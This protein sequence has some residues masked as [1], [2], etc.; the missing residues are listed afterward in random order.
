MPQGIYGPY[1][2]VAQWMTNKPAWVPVDHQERIMAYEIYEALYWSHIDLKYK[3][4]TRDT[5][6]D[7]PVYVP[8]SKIIVETVNR[9]VGN[10]FTFQVEPL[11]GTPASRA[12]ALQTLTALFRR[13]RFVSRYNANKRYGTIRGDWG[14][15]LMADP[16][17]VAGSRIR[18]LPFNAASYFPVT[19][20][21]RIDG[22]DPDRIVAVHLAERIQVGDEYRVRRQSY[23]TLDN[24]TIQSETVLCEEDKWWPEGEE[25][26]VS[27]IA[28]ILPPTVLPADITSIPVYHVP[29]TCEPGYLFGSSELR[30]LEV[31]AASLNQSV[32][33]EDLALALIGLG[34]YATDQAGSPIDPTTGQPRDWFIYPGA[35]IENSKGLRRVEGITSVAPYDSHIERLMKFAREASAATDAATG[36]VDVAVAESGVAL[37]LELG[38]ILAKAKEQDQ[39]IADV[40]NQMLFDLRTWLRVY[41]GINIDDV[42]IVA[43]FGDKIPP[44]KAKETELVNTLVM[45]R[46]MSA[47]TAREHLA[48]V[49]YANVFAPDEEERILVEVAAI[50]AAE[51]GGDGLGERTDAELGGTVDPDSSPDQALEPAPGT[52]AEA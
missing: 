45:N 23:E 31:L 19:E 25:A 35:V 1:S 27:V 12:L 10:G 8:S 46:I 50:S 36:R 37:T 26:E 13:E 18:I 7:S 6:E 41:E 9:Y 51:G 38:P 22:G 14:W 24:G 33:D 17:K 32:T 2:T 42:S 3:I 29:N 30:G 28:Q 15:H 34:V 11:V 47:Q 20:A 44:N 21:D 49:G 16:N 4:M 48:R 52:P 39:V 43:A 5:T 40:H